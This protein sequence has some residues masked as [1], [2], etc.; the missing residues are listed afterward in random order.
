VRHV[1]TAHG[2][3]HRPRRRR[4]GERHVH[5]QRARDRVGSTFANHVT[6]HFNTT[7]N[8][9]EFFFFTNCHN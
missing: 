5:L 3:G 1:H 6:D 7:P 8:G 4:R 2:H 9:A